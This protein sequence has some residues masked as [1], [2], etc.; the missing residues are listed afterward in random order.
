LKNPDNIV[1]WYLDEAKGI[2]VPV[3]N[4]KYDASTGKVSFTVT[5]FSKYAV[6]YVMP[7]L[8]DIGA[9]SW[10]EKQI[11][12]VV[13]KG[14]MKSSG[15]AGFDPDKSITRAEFIY[16]LIRSLGLSSGF[17]KSFA[18]VNSSDYYYQELGA[19]KALGIAQGL[20]N[21]EFKPDA[22]ITRQ[23]M[24]VLIERALKAAG[25]LNA[26]AAADIASYEDSSEITAYARVSIS[27]MAAEGIIIGS[28]NRINP[29]GNTTRAEAAVILYR[30]NNK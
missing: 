29:R 23:D 5:H 2:P 14:I 9:L 20:G 4:C 22:A 15:E 30:I 11:S 12:S 16:G 21:N 7:D 19:A 17:D 24:A 28:G 3:S 13:A 10:A 1:I 6:C 26:S 27:R 18:D 8:K 25:K